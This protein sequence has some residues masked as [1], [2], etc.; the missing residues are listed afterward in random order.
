M[1]GPANLSWY[2]VFRKRMG[3]EMEEGMTE[4]EKVLNHRV[5]W[6]RFNLFVAMRGGQNAEK[7]MQHH[8]DLFKELHPGAT[9]EDCLEEIMLCMMKKE[10]AEKILESD[11]HNDLKES[12]VFNIDRVLE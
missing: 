8:F 10:A 9:L 7:L 4:E 5:S 12:I 6:S 2:E 3:L 1:R 11:E